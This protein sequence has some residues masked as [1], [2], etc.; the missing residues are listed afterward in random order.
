MSRVHPKQVHL[1]KSHLA[2]SVVRLATAFE[3]V[4]ATLLKGPA[5]PADRRSASA[6]VHERPI[7][8]TRIAR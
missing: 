8:E 6:L 1:K 7:S 3:A 5:Q 2:P 4:G